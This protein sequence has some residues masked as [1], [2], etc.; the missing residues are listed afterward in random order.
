MEKLAIAAHT[1]GVH[2]QP[3]TISPNKNRVKK[4]S[5]VLLSTLAVITLLAA[6]S[7]AAAYAAGPL[8]PVQLAMEA[9]MTAQQYDA[10][11]LGFQF[12]SDSN[13]RLSYSSYVDPAGQT[14][15][16]SLKSGSTYLGQSISLNAAGNL[17]PS[18]KTW[19]VLS[20]GSYGGNLWQVTTSLVPEISSNTSAIG[21]KS[22]AEF[23]PRQD[24]QK[25]LPPVEDKIDIVC[26][27]NWTGTGFFD[28]SVETCR[29][30]IGD[31]CGPSWISHDGA[32][33]DAE[34]QWFSTSNVIYANLGL[35]SR[36]SAP[37]EGGAGSFS[38]VV[39]PAQAPCLSCSIEAGGG[40]N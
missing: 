5:S 16:F 23:G 19:N 25:H 40:G 8:T 20:S 14:F 28:F 18:T 10:T 36:G 32:W 15:T 30:C 37:I 17:D 2:F 24:L 4:T 9:M 33:G 38:T 7:P 6:L 12:G 21:Y 22:V 13:S 31:R 35:S 26:E 3:T 34:L 11:F 39:G 1:P 29:K 27:G